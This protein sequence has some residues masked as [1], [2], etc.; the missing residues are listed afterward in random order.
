MSHVTVSAD[1]SW[2]CFGNI[3]FLLK[4]PGQHSSGGTRIFI[5]GV[6]SAGDLGDSVPQW[7]PGA[8]LKH[9]ADIH[10]LIVDKYISR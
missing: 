5:W 8:K 4:T 7:D 9:F 10:L 2:T 3:D 1:E 6:C